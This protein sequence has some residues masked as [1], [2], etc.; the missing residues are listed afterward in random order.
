MSAAAALAV[1][2]VAYLV[3]GR[4]LGLLRF[5]HWPGRWH[6]SRHR[7]GFPQRAR[8]MRAPPAT[9]LGTVGLGT[10]AWVSA[11][12]VTGSPWIGLPAGVLAASIALR[13]RARHRA[14]AL[15]EL[16]EAW[17]DGLRQLVAAVRSGATVEAG[18]VEMAR[19]GPEPLREAFGR[20]AALAAAMGVAAALETVRDAARDAT[21]D[22][23]IEVLIVAHETGGRVVPEVLDDLAAAVTEDLRTVEEV[24]TAGLEQRLNARIVFAVPW[25][26][27]LLLTSR[28]GMY[29]DFYA[30]PPGTTII[31]TAALLSGI[32]LF[33]VGRLG[34]EPLEQRVL[35]DPDAGDGR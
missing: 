28:Q 5:E 7:R 26:L 15:E 27:L 21:T 11:T 10:A 20:F 24:R 34:R 32:A 19:T 9:M 6:R 23:V 30:S 22:R 33:L 18:V 12:A 25:G 2:V 8:I 1:S 13:R 4:L 17:P 31:L 29:R 16:Q 3:A 35:V 14:R